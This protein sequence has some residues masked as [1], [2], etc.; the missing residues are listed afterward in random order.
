M[1]SFSK[2]EGIDK[3]NYENKNFKVIKILNEF[4]FLY[5]GNHENKK[6]YNGFVLKEK[7]YINLF[8]EP[9]VHNWVNY[10]NETVEELFK[11]QIRIFH[12]KIVRLLIWIFLI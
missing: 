11:K 5:N 12:I 1:F 3:I 10:D 8:F 6:L 4:S 7:K 9:N 2:L